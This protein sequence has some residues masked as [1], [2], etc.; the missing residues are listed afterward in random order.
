MTKK[1]TNVFKGVAIIL[2]FVHHL[3]G[4]A[5]VLKDM[6]VHPFVPTNILLMIASAGKVCVAI[7][8]FASAM[9]SQ[10][11]RKNQ[12]TVIL[13]EE[14]SKYGCLFSLFTFCGDCSS[15]DGKLESHLRKSVAE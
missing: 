6:N 2:M 12:M 14:S 10:N 9:V 5:G 3:F 8:V 15:C 13:P 11:N 1:Q 7:F 4:D